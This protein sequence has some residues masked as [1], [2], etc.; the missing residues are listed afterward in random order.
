MTD[1]LPDWITG[2][3][4]IFLVLI[5]LTWIN[6]GRRKALEKHALVL[7]SDSSDSTKRQ[8]FFSETLIFHEDIKQFLNFV[9]IL[10]F[11]IAYRLT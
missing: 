2:G 10:L 9:L 11:Y 4:W 1:F 8:Y 6:Q 5:L 7:D 3:F